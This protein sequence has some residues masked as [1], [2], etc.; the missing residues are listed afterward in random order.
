MGDMGDIFRAMRDD[1]KERHAKN[2]DE[3]HALARALHLSFETKNGGEHLVFDFCGEVA[4]FWPSSGKWFQR[5]QKKYGHGLR[6]LVKR[7]GISPNRAET[8][9]DADS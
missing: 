5:R 2:Y 1:K 3:N 8:K 6:A 4:D 9:T 7:Y